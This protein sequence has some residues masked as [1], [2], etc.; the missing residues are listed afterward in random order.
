MEAFASVVTIEKASSLQMQPMR[1]TSCPGTRNS[2][3]RLMGFPVFGDGYVSFWL[4]S[5]NDG[6]GTTHRRCSIDSRQV[7]FIA[8]SMRVLNTTSGFQDSANP[9]ESSR[10]SKLPAPSRPIP[11]IVSKVG[12]MSGT[13]DFGKAS[14]RRAGQSGATFKGASN[15][16][17]RTIPSTSS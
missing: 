9:H 15:S 3:W 11:R 12:T 2:Y 4:V 8:L 1:T 14:A 5:K 17:S 7:G 13:A 6:T 10:A 16:S